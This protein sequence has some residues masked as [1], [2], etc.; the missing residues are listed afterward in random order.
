MEQYTILLIILA[1]IILITALSERISLSSPIML[2]ISGLL[3]SFIPDFNEVKV[4]PEIIFLLFLPPLLYDAAVKIP[5]HDF[6]ANFR[7]ISSLAFGL[8]FMTTLGIGALSHYMIPGMSWSTAF[9]LGAILAA[10]DAVAAI[11]ITKNI[12]LSHK[13]SVILEGESLLNDASALVAYKFAVAAV[14]GTVFVWWQAGIEF[15]L[16]LLGG[17]VVGFA[18]AYI[19]VFFLRIVRK[20]RAAVNSFLLLAPFVT[21][22]LAEELNVSGV[23][24]VV[25]LGFIISSK[26]KHHFSNEIKMQSAHLWEIIIFLLNGLVFILI[27]LE[28]NV[29]GQ[30][31][32]LQNMGVLSLYALGITILS[33]LIRGLLLFRHRRKLAQAASLRKQNQR[34]SQ[35][36]PNEEILSIQECIIISFSGMRGIVSLAIALGIPYFL[37]DG[38]P[39]P[40]RSEILFITFMVILFTV[41]GQGLLLPF[42]VRKVGNNNERTVEIQA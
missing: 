27:G 8:V 15:V 9:V 35:N 7:T 6:K 37:E 40:L 19:F 36:A 1:L 17:A 2:I 20:N 14:A 41:I 12:G 10:T 4:D 26:G 22:L 25:V 16:L 31:V 5:Q 3:L 23:I 18:V 13:A 11:G 30:N 39:F 34:H 29:V 32:S 21:Y 33:I 24:A 42:I 38:T 28:L